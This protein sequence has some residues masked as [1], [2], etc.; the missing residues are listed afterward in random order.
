[1]LQQPLAGDGYQFFRN[2]VTDFG[3]DSS[4]GTD[5]TE[6]INAAVSSW[7][8]SSAG[9]GKSRCGEECGNTFSQGA[10]VYFPPGT[11]KVCTPIIQL[12][13]TQFI[14]DANNPPTIKGCDSFKGIALIDTDPYIPGGAGSQWYVNQNQF[15]RHIR[16]FIFDLT[17]MPNSTNENDQPLV[18]TGIHWQAAQATTLQNLVFNMP[19]SG[20]TNAQNATTA[21]G[22]FMVG[23]HPRRLPSRIETDFGPGKW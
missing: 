3:A 9:G 8:S 21:V 23:S 7:S 20:G 11:Y 22:I 12:Y 19:A 4:G 17:D 5:A 16:N 10:I 6:A 13:Y 15:F 2:V 14:G 18:P 1:M